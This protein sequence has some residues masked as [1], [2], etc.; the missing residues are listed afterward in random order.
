[1]LTNTFVTWAPHSMFRFIKQD[2]W[3]ADGKE[4]K[5]HH[6]CANVFTLKGVQKSVN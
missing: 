2:G 6:R 5:I 3:Q 1:M 4:I